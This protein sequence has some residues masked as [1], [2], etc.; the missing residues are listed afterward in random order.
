MCILP[1]NCH[2][3]QRRFLI[4]WLEMDAASLPSMSSRGYLLSGMY[5]SAEPFSPFTVMSGGSTEQRRWDWRQVMS[6]WFGRGDEAS[7]QRLYRELWF[8]STG[9]YQKLADEVCPS[10]LR[11]LT[12]HQLEW[13]LL[14]HACL[15]AP[16]SSMD[17]QKIRSE[18]SELH[19][20]AVRG[21]SR[22]SRHF[23]PRS[24]D[25]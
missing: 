13:R 20:A 11:S 14:L 6:T 7:L 12:L 25:F 8:P 23:P 4:L 2:S 5:S 21:M 22:L 24:F 18:F 1:K 17:G 19:K 3:I 16:N 15:L 9:E 10:R